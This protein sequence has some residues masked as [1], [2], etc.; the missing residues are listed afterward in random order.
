LAFY[1]QLVALG[2][3]QGEIAPEIDDS[4]AAYIFD[5]VFSGLTQYIVQQIFAGQ[6]QPDAQRI[7]LT[8]PEIA[9]V[10]EQTFS[11][12]EYGLRPRT[13]APPAAQ[14]LAVKMDIQEVDA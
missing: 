4:L 3:E 2:K 8:R 5:S 14:P 10:Y 1:R 11:I 13:P 12:L 9:A 7:G 6:V